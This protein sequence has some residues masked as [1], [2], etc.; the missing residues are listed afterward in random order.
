M[1]CGQ[2]KPDSNGRFPQAVAVHL[3]NRDSTNSLRVELV[4]AAYGAAEISKTIAS[5]QEAAI[6]VDLTESSGWY[7]FTVRTDSNE[8]FERTFAG[9]VETGALSTSDPAMA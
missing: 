4:D 9:R 7:D 5:N 8:R 3:V 6:K 2:G 1:S